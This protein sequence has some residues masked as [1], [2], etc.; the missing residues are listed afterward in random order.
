MGMTR[1]SNICI[2][3]AGQGPIDSI[4]A[5]Q[6]LPALIF[7]GSPD[8]N[9]DLRPRLFQQALHEERSDE[10]GAAGEQT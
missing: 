6:S 1:A 7:V 8:E 5:L 2:S 3:P 4:A 9:I 10:T